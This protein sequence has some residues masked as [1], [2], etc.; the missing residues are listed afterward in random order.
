MNIFKRVAALSILTGLS[1]TAA[2]A[3]LF[4]ADLFPGY[5]GAKSG[6]SSELYILPRIFSANLFPENNATGVSQSPTLGAANLNLGT[7]VQYHFQ[8]DTIP[9]M[10]S[11]GVEPLF[12]F[13]QASAQSFPGQGAFSGQNVTISV[14][15]DAY[16]AVSTG[17]FAF[18]SNSAK[19]DANTLYYWRARAKSPGATF[20][21]WSSTRSF[22]TARFAAQSPANQVEISGVNLSGATSTGTVT[23]NFTIAENNVTTGTSSGGGAYNT[24]DWIFVKF[25]TMSGADGSWNHA[26]LTGGSVGAGA[27]LTAASDYK[28]VFLDH[29][30]NSAYWTAGAAVNWN[31]GADGIVLAKVRVKVFAVS[32]VHVPPGSFVYNAGNTGGTASNNIPGPKTVDSS[33]ADDLP[34]GA[35]AGWPNGFSGFYIGRYELTQGQYADFLNTVWSSTAAVLYYGGVATGHNMTN[36]GSYPNKYAAV[37]PNAAKNFLSVSDA[38]SYMSWAGLRPPTEMEFEKAGRDIGGDTRVYPW[39]DTMP[40]S[41]PTYTPPNEGGNCTRVYIN[42]TRLSDFVSCGK[43]IDVGRYMSGDIYRMAEE[44][45]ASPWSI[46]DLAG[47]VSEYILN[48]AYASVPSNGNGTVYWP[49]NWPSPA[50][51]G[52]VAYGTRGGSW[53]GYSITSF[54][55]ARYDVDSP[56]NDRDPYTGAR[57]ARLP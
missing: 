14:S 55:S 3:S 50:S 10:N 24:A 2:P 44:T 34:A 11:Q 15:S 30:A 17:T 35:P 49:S 16:S 46:A 5:G 52:S 27:A 18:Y 38:W 31:F 56:G 4:A 8:V 43:V 42:V 29:T 39:G 40:S 12:S 13:N 6:A 51:S 33:L 22:T 21:A 41:P 26:T 54:L 45:G 20:G 37:D 53:S 32:M 36:S 1:L 23:I 28:G 25:S 7:S 9:G 19:L 47:N 57:A 48:S